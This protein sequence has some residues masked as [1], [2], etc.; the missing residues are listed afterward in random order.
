[1]ALPRTVRD[2]R[3]IGAFRLPIP[4]S[5]LPSLLRGIHDLDAT[6]LRPAILA[7]LGAGRALFAVADHADL[8][9]GTAVGLQGGR[10]GVAA[11]LG[12]AHVVLAAAAL[13]GM[14]F[15]VHARGRTVAQVLGVAGHRGFELGT[16]GIL[17]EVEVHDAGA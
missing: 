17:V 3:T 11:A 8:A 6:I 4:G 13:V 2:F 7:R 15:E 5:R 10:H 12:Q 9:A 16:D 14:A 1:A